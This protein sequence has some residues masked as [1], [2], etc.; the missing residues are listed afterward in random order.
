[1]VRTEIISMKDL[2]KSS[3]KIP[4]NSQ[5]SG[6]KSERLHKTC[7]KN[8]EGLT[9]KFVGNVGILSEFQG[10]RKERAL[11]FVSDRCSF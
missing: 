11:S 5:I 4:K 9:T 3:R 7:S 6:I 1:M 10:N 8:R 2:L